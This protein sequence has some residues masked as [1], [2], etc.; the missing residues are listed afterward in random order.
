MQFRCEFDVWNSTYVIEVKPFSQYSKNESYS[1]LEYNFIN[2]FE[3]KF[4]EYLVMFVSDESLTKVNSPILEIG[5]I[6][7]Q[8][9]SRDF[10]QKNYRRLSNNIT[11]KTSFLRSLP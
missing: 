4:P 1:E 3:S 5:N 7:L 8:S 2:E 6:P 11:E 9:F 10:A